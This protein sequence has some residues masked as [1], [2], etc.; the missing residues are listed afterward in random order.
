MDNVDVKKGRGSINM[1]AQ[2]LNFLTIRDA[3]MIVN[4]VEDVEKQDLN[5]RVKRILKPR[6]QE[7]LEW[8]ERSEKELLK[9]YE[10]ERAYLRS[11]VAALKLYSGW[12]KPYLKT[13]QKL[14]M[15]DFR[16]PDIV[17]VFN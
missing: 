17:N 12:T 15:K 10:I 14:G 7:F 1:L 2:D 8:K 11:Q 16:S 5:D 9:R 13:A 4:S 6:M 3:F